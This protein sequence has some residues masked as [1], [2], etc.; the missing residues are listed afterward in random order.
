MLY[1]CFVFTGQTAC[2]SLPEAQC[3]RPFSAVPKLLTIVR[4]SQK[5]IGHEVRTAPGD[6]R[7]IS[8]GDHGDH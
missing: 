8:A 2:P 5:L 1:K 4:L 3:I 7:L 6:L